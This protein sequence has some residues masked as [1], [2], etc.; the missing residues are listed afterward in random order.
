MRE[1][2]ERAGVSRPTV[3]YVLNGQESGQSISEATKTR[4]LEAA[5]ELGY[6]RNTLARAIAT[7]KY[8]V[9]G[10]LRYQADEQFSLLLDGVLHEADSHGYTVKVITREGRTIEPELI[11]RC[12]ELR[13]AGLIGVQ[14]KIGDSKAIYSEL[15]RQTIPMVMLDQAESHPYFCRV[16]AQDIEAI[17]TVVDHLVQLGHHRIQFLGSAAPARRIGFER[18]MQKHGLPVPAE[19]PWCSYT[20]D[21]SIEK[22]TTDLLRDAPTRPTAIVCISDPMAMV[23]CRT[24]RALGLQVPRDLSVTGYDD[25]LMAAR[26]DPPLTTVAQPFFE[27]G[28]CAVRQLLGAI[29][30]VADPTT[31]DFL[32]ADEQLLPTQLVVRRST[33]PAPMGRP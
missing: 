1:V 9:I 18:A 32:R 29:K 27:M 24:A 25:L 21:D 23:V 2:A 7:G 16:A 17:G 14:V 30:V 12:A 15:V 31:P 19:L 10:F 26:A 28:R 22:I 6:R 11:Q 13:L 33:G 8:N 20:D 5:H 3:S 4:V